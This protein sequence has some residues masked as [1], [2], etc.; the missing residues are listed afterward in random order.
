MFWND[1]RTKGEQSHYRKTPTPILTVKKTPPPQKH[2]QKQYH[3]QFNLKG[4]L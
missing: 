4:E 2:R 3:F 1:N